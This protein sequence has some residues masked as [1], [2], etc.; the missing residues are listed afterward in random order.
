MAS[1]ILKQFD[2]VGIAVNSTDCALKIYRDVLG[3][4]V[5]IYKEMGTTNDYLFTQLRLGK[6][7]IELLESISGRESFLTRFLSRWGEGLHHL[8]FQVENIQRARDYLTSQGLRITDEFYE[9]PLWKTAFVSPKST[10]G[11]LIQLYE[12]IPGS[13]Y[14]HSS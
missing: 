8:T 1:E 7:R 11:V 12:T 10:S 13:K 4:E 14:D 9:D 2:H 6:Q 3:G 5:T